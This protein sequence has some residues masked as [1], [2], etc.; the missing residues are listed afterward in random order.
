MLLQRSVQSNL[1]VKKFMPYE[2]KQHCFVISKK[3][4]N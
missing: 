2:V 3:K 1:Y 4:Q